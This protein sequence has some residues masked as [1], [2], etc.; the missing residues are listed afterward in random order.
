MKS[1]LL[2]VADPAEP[3][4]EFDFRGPWF[5]GREACAY[6]GNKTMGGWYAWKKR[7]HV[8][9]RSNGTVAKA[10]LDRALAPKNRKP[11]RMVPAQLANLRHRVG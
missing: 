7:H 9:A 6:V 2:R 5:G 3:L 1:A 8:V 10:D 11:R 4:P